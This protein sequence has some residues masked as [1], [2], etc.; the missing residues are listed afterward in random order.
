MLLIHYSLFK[1]W[2]WW[3][4]RWETSVLTSNQR[5]SNQLLRWPAERRSRWRSRNYLEV[6][7]GLQTPEEGSSSSDTNVSED[8]E[9]KDVNNNVSPQKPLSDSGSTTEDGCVGANIG[10]GRKIY[11]SP[12]LFHCDDCGKR[13]TRKMTLNTHMRVH[14]GDKPFVCDVCRQRFNWRNTLNIYSRVQTG[15]KP[16]GCD[17]CGQIFSH[18]TTLVTHMK[19]HTGQRPFDCDICGQ[20]FS[21]QAHLITHT[22][23]ST[24]ETNP[25][26]AM[27]VVKYSATRPL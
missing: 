13:F 24:R 11:T 12:K 3:W 18:K 16:F 9:D 7:H 1:E 14:T 15:Q 22:R 21:Q 17:V 5:S 10:S 4:W 25:S 27:S 2:K 20:K 19:V 6:K 23:G 26:T 8:E